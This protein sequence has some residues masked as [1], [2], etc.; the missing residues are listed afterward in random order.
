MLS[1]ASFTTMSSH[2]DYTVADPDLGVRGGRGG[3]GGGQPSSIRL[4]SLAKTK[5]LK[6]TVAHKGHYI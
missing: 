4:A 3:G 5:F 1:E 6:T 2:G